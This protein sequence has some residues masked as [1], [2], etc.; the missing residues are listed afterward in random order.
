MCGRCS[1]K[2]NGKTRLAC[3]ELVTGDL[4]LEPVL[5]DKVVRDLKVED[6]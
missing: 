2:V 4:K 5:S 6:I 3:G 1:I